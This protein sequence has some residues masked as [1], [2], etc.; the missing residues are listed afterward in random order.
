M[1]KLLPGLIVA[2]LSGLTFLAYK[3]PLA[4]HKIYTWL[5]YVLYA[6]AA[7]GMIWDWSNAVTTGA[8]YQF[9]GLE[10]IDEVTKI[11]SELKIFSRTM[12]IGWFL[13]MMYLL[14]LD[15][16]PLILGNKKKQPPNKKGYRKGEKKV[17]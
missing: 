14:F 3:H 2:A 4:Y 7:V 16:L 6:F 13:F 11:T 10:K 15:N 9:V 5:M 12:W 17:N 1:D 8:I